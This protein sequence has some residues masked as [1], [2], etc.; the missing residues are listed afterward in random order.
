MNIEGNLWISGASPSEL[1]KFQHRSNHSSAK[2]N[3]ALAFSDNCILIFICFILDDQC[4]TSVKDFLKLANVSFFW[5]SFRVVDW[6]CSTLINFRLPACGWVRIKQL[7]NLPI[8][9]H[10]GGCLSSH[11]C[12]SRWHNNMKRNILSINPGKLCTKQEIIAVMT[13]LSEGLPVT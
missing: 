2:Y 7:L 1:Q 12:S 8:W 3:C 11:H 13:S 6:H 10:I 9:Y 5:C 4:K